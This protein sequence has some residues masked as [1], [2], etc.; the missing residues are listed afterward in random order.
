MNKIEGAARFSWRLEKLMHQKGIHNNAALQREL[1]AH[2]ISL[3]GSQ[4]HRLVTQTPERLNLTV[5]AA[6]CE[7]LTCGPGD[8]IEIH[9]VARR[10]PAV[11]DDNVVDLAETARPRRAQ[12]TKPDKP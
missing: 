2:G 6:L 8:L 4:T 12:V 5:L 9:T 11:G 1:T 7:I 10:R 3:S